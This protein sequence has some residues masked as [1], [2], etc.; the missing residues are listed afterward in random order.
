[1]QKKGKELGKKLWKNSSN[2]LFKGVHKKSS[3][4]LGKKLCKN[5]SKELA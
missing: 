4:K 2:E 3:K 1:M 5:S